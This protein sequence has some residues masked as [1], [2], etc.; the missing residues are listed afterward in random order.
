MQTLSQLLPSAEIGTALRRISVNCYV[1]AQRNRDLASANYGKLFCFRFHKKRP[2]RI[3]WFDGE[4]CVTFPSWASAQ[5]AVVALRNKN[6][7]LWDA[8][9]IAAN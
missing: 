5:K 4:V 8:A 7:L 6:S 1:T 9:V 2:T 3:E